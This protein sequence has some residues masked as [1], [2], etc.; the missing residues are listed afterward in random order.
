VVRARYSWNGVA[1]T[2]LAAAQGDLEGLSP[3]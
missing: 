2:M 3:P 1:R